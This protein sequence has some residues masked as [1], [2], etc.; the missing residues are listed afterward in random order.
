MS[1]MTEAA[2]TTQRY[3]LKL[4]DGQ[5]EVL[6]KW[7]FL[8]DADLSSPYLPGLLNERLVALTRQAVAANEPMDAPRLEVWAGDVKVLDWAG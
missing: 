8:L 2:M 3:Q 4:F 6:H 7:L 5:Y 1:L